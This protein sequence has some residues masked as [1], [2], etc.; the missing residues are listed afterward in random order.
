[1]ASPSFFWPS[2]TRNI[3]FS[4][5][6]STCQCFFYFC[7]L[8]C[9]LFPFNGSATE[10]CGTLVTTAS[11]FSSPT[12]LVAVASNCLNSSKTFLSSCIDHNKIQSTNQVQTYLGGCLQPISK[13]Q[14]SSQVQTFL[15]SCL[16]SEVDKSSNSAQVQTYLSSYLGGVDSSKLHNTA[17]VQTYFSNC[18]G[19]VNS[20]KIRNSAEVQ[21]YLSSCLAT[22]SEQETQ[23]ARYSQLR[24]T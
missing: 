18:L 20:G 22:V 19:E 3:Q 11:S 5:F 12:G 21:T 6:D 24:F 10:I 8:T 7:A 1:M 4:D 17:Q 23:T 2:N 16:Q 13:M 15:S 9:I 14:H